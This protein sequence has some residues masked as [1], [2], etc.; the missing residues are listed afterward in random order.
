MK[1]SE[2]ITYISCSPIKGLLINVLEKYG[3]N[4]DQPASLSG[5]YHIGETLNLHI[6]KTLDFIFLLC[7]EFGIIDK[8]REILIASA[9]LHDIGNC[10]FISKTRN[11]KAFEKLYPNGY[12]RA[13]ETYL[14]HPTLGS[15]IIGKYILECKELEPE[16]FEISRLVESH[17]SHWLV[18]YNRF[19][20]S[21]FEYI[22]C[23]AD[24]LA[25]RRDII[26]QP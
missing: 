16:L 2:A 18:D 23:T 15:F 21:L 11:E 4:L 1:I 3:R 6:E 22:L 12:N 26:Y 17:M 13:R 14:Y 9:I 24:F 10:E 19:P 20:E 25:S 5:K 8:D 7:E